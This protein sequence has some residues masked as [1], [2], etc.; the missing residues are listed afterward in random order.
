M[1]ES[2]AIW[3]YLLDTYDT[4]CLLYPKELDKRQKVDKMMLTNATVYRPAFK[5]SYF[6]IKDNELSPVWFGVEAPWQ[7]FLDQNTLK[8]NNVMEDINHITSNTEYIA[9]DFKSIADIHVY[10][11]VFNVA[12]HL[13]LNL[14][15]YPSL[16]T[17]YSKFNSDE[18][19]QQL[20]KE[21]TKALSQKFSAKVPL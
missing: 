1:T 6:D 3:K 12:Y 11:E 8:I 5:E 10:N 2:A 7:D 18:I 13:D 9:G 21:A 19:M 15:K 4:S 16:S 17:W 20:N 14:S